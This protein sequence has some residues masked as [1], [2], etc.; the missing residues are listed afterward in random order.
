MASRCPDCNQMLCEA[1][2]EAGPVSSES[3]PVCPDWVDMD[4]PWNRYFY[5]V[6]T[7]LVGHHRASSK[8]LSLGIYCDACGYLEV[9]R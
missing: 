3:E 8:T 1:R 4:D 9:K 7:A 5:N 6:I 2:I